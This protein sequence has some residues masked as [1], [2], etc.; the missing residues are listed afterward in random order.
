MRKLIPYMTK[1]RVLLPVLWLIATPSV[2]A[3]PVI[4]SPKFR[5]N[6]EE[7]TRPNKSIEKPVPHD[8]EDRPPNIPS[9]EEEAKSYEEEFRTSDFKKAEREIKENLSQDKQ[10][11]IRNFMRP[12]ICDFLKRRMQLLEER[13]RKEDEE[14]NQDEEGNRKQPC[15]FRELLRTL[16]SD[17]VEN[18]KELLPDTIENGVEIASNPE[19]AHAICVTFTI[20]VLKETAHA[21]ADA[22][23]HG[24]ESCLAW[25][26][27]ITST[28][29]ED[30]NHLVDDTLDNTFPGTAT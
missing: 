9:T 1:R 28:L 19:L 8:D 15:N 25:P 22:V 18:A 4:K 13:I 12:K 27:A 16:R 23:A 7:S 30:A 6:V 21:F 10:N 17:L 29:E 3:F 24:M 2:W 14:R 20:N 26:H 5:P 11:E